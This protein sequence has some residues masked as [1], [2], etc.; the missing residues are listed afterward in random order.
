MRPEVHAN[1][2]VARPGAQGTF[3][4]LGLQILNVAH[5]SFPLHSHRQHRRVNSGEGVQRTQKCGHLG[6]G[7]WGRGLSVNAGRA[8]TKRYG[9]ERKVVRRLRTRC[10]P[11]DGKG[12]RAEF[13]LDAELVATKIEQLSR[14]ERRMLLWQELILLFLFRIW[15]VKRA[16]NETSSLDYWAGRQ[17]ML[18]P[19]SD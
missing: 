7:F 17:R 16:D 11:H 8:W 9:G 19:K 5:G 14:R 12:S 15:P 10:E 3:L 13:S 6:Q 2:A 1:R 18:E 4:L